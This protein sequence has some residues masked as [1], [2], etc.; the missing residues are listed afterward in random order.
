MENIDGLTKKETK[1]KG[2]I[3]K[4]VLL[5]LLVFSIYQQIKLINLI[6]NNM[7]KLDADPLVYAAN[8]YDMPP[9]SCSNG[10]ITFVF[11][12]NKSKIVIHTKFIDSPSNNFNISQFDNLLITK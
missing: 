10:N 1:R 6:K 9:C 12:K 5:I 7:E 2:L 3:L 8:K 11:D 4:L